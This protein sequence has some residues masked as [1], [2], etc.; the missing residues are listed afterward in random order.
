[1]ESLLF[2]SFRISHELKV[3]PKLFIQLRS[4]ERREKKESQ[5][6]AESYQFFPGTIFGTASIAA[7]AA[8]ERNG[9]KKWC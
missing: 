2:L 3:G 5:E 6:Y 8:V 9:I 4:E 1:M 7:R